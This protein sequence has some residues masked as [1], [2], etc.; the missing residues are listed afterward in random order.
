MFKCRQSK[1]F[2]KGIF[3]LHQQIPRDDDDHCWG[4][5][6]RNIRN[7]HQ[8]MF[9]HIDRTKLQCALRSECSIWFIDSC[10]Y[11][12][13]NT[14]VIQFLML[15]TWARQVSSWCGLLS[16]ANLVLLTS[17]WKQS[18]TWTN[19][20]CQLLL[21][22]LVLPNFTPTCHKIPSVNNLAMSELSRR[23]KWQPYYVWLATDHDH[24]V[25][26]NS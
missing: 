21:D 10:L 23:L 2:K 15:C 18:G 5:S 1:V 22:G 16:E 6:L 20:T 25:L 11:K 3:K 7:A 4:R 19:H 13:V 24:L 26:V 17:L 8:V 9:M 14:L 12:Y